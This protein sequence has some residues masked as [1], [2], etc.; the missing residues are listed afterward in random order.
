MPA[1]GGLIESAYR[2]DSSRGGWTTEADFL[3]GQRTDP[4]GVIAVIRAA[5][6]RMVTVEERGELI[7]CCQ[8]ERR[9][10]HAYFGMFAVR[11]ARQGAGIGKGIL[12]EAERFTRD[13]WSVGE[14]HMTV[15]SVRDDLIA[16]Y[17]RPHRVVRTP[18]LPAHR[19][20]HPVPVR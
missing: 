18:R 10:G 3:D 20:V 8:L 9:D 13:E 11:P 16:W 4:D 12:A 6:S 17:E 2:G 7:A 5:D 14:M 19:P 1:L 15:I